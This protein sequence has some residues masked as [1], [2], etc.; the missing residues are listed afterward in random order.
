MGKPGRV[1]I[2]TQRSRSTI[3]VWWLVNEAGVAGV[4]GLEP[5]T[6]AVTGQRSNQ[7]SYTPAQ[8]EQQL[9]KTLCSRQ[10]VNPGRS[11]AASAGR[12]LNFEKPRAQATSSKFHPPSSNEA[13][14]PKHQTPSSKLQ[15]SSKLQAQKATCAPI[16]TVSV[17]GGL[18]FESW[19]FS[20]VWGLVLGVS[21]SGRSNSAMRSQSPYQRHQRQLPI[22]SCYRS[23]I[24]A[25]LS[26]S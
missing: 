12:I 5:V 26:R 4:A 1:A 20:G 11:S 17:F 22:W 25:R 10:R 14:G 9:R 13:L 21:L 15:R 16:A 19:N 2:R 23:P 3:P 18:V 7:L 24:S 6:S 8:A